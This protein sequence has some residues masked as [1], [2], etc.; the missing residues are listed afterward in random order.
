M[1]AAAAGLATVELYPRQDELR[2]GVGSL[3]RLPLGVHRKAEPPRRFHFVQADGETP[4]APT[5]REQVA[6]LAQPKTLPVRFVEDVLSRAPEPKVVFPTPAF[7]QRKHVDGETVAERIKQAVSVYDFVSQFVDLDRSGRGLCCFHDDHRFSFS[8][9]KEGNYW[10][11]FSGCGGGSVIDFWLKWRQLHGQRDDF[12][13]TIKD[14][15]EM[16]HL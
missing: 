14:L 12:T 10:N 15:M 9:N 11:C 2:T 16:L 4:L 8:I 7:E 13:E 6:L 3:V 5:V 1:V